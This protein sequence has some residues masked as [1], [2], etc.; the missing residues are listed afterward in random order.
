MAALAV[1]FFGRALA[2]GCS[3]RTSPSGTGLIVIIAI[4]E[5]LVAIGLATRD[6]PLDAGRELSQRCSDSSSRPRSGSCTSTSS[7]LESGSSSPIEAARTASR[8]HET[9]TRTASCRWSSASSSRFAIKSTLAHLGEEL[10]TVEALVLCGGP[11]PVRARALRFRVSRTFGRGRTA[12]AIACALLIPSPSSCR[13]WSRSRSWPPSGSRSTPTAL[14]WW[15][16]A[17]AEARI[18]PA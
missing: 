3:P 5:S 18:Q 2:G 16:E 13:R 9:S 1:G 7:R 17:R 14:I 10:G 8:S 15:R 4:G 6:T 12:A 11:L